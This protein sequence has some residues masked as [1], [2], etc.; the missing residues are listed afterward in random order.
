[1]GLK[2]IANVA[3]AILLTVAMAVPGIGCV[4]SKKVAHTATFGLVGDKENIEKAKEEKQAR[5]QAE[6]DREEQKKA[7][8]KQRKQARK[9]A[10]QQKKADKKARKEAKN[11][12]PAEPKE[13]RGFWNKATL[14]L[15]GSDGKSSD[16][17]EVAAAPE[18][19]SKKEAKQARKQEKREAEQAKKAE[20]RERKE[21][22]KQEERDKEAAEKQAKQERKEAKSSEEKEKRGF[23]NKATLG[24]VGGG[25]KAEEEKEASAAPE[26]SEKTTKKEEK[27]AR[28]EARK[29]EERDKE[30]A[31]KQ[32]KQERKEAKAQEKS[33][34]E[35]QESE[36]EKRGFW[37]KATFGLVGGGKEE[38][39]KSDEPSAQT[40]QA[41]ASTEGGV[42][43]ADSVDVAKADQQA[44]AVD[45]PTPIRGEHKGLAKIS[46]KTATTK[47][48]ET[49]SGLAKLVV[50]RRTYSENGY[51]ICDLGDV[52]IAVKGM[53]FPGEQRA[54]GVVI[55]SDER[56]VAAGKSGRG[57]EAFAFQYEKGVTNCVFGTVQFSITKG[58]LTIDGHDV[59]MVTGRKLVVLDEN[60]K[61]DAV[62]NIG[63]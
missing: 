12:E 53:T 49:R 32:A 63:K 44:P 19:P 16:E 24:L 34:K 33:E 14:G 39:A 23:W 21:A 45:P 3:M 47:E 54:G 29:Q 46:F 9:E 25:E 62:Y 27:K 1:M 52:R 13:K 28:K 7:E 37:S 36:K 5:K 10:E 4:T 55:Q 17:N 51:G 41:A 35:Q 20:K 8:K 42:K 57:N 61:V 22:R 18:K 30:A 31:K 50:S 6:R 15:V 2:R 59:S 40:E 26:Q 60:G 48:G 58:V 11:D 56:G 38:E 43:E